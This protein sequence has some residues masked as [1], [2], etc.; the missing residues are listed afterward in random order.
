MMWVGTRP[1]LT[2]S[3]AATAWMMAL[4]PPPQNTN[5]IFPYLFEPSGMRILR[6]NVPA[7]PTPLRL[8]SEVLA[9]L[10]M[11]HATP[12]IHSACSRT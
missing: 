7:A 9:R 11:Y 4:H 6:L 5:R 1:A 12:K 3:A 10:W 8:N 2:T